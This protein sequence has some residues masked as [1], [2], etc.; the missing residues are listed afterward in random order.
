MD[1]NKI[2]FSYSR[3]D[4]SDFTLRL[5]LDLKKEGFNV[6]I[7]QQDIRAGTEWDLEIEKALETCDCLLFIESEKSVSSN[8]VL[9]EV[10]YALEQRKRV[11]PVIYHDSKTPFRLQRL[12]HIDFTKDYQTGLGNLIEELKRVPAQEI[13]TPA[14]NPEIKQAT[15][16]FLTKY[17]RHLLAIAFLLVIAI[18]AAFIYSSNKEKDIVQIESKELTTNDTL[19]NKQP[20]QD[21]PELPVVPKKENIKSEKKAS[22]NAANKIT[23]RAENKVV[24]PNTDK[25]EN[26]VEAYAGE[27]ELAGVEPKAKSQRGFLRISSIDERKVKILSSFQF[28]FFKP[29]TE[30]HF[31]VFNGFAACESCVLQNEIKIID[32]DVAFGSNRYEILKKD[33]PDKGK[34]GDTVMNRG[35]NNSIS[36]LVTLHLINSNS[37]TIKVQQS[38][39]TPV[40]NDLVVEPFEYSFMFVKK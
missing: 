1:L 13:F 27:W 22:G 39:P 37:I 14:G 11:I 20:R 17:S 2:F 28:Y 33:D 30:A 26:L 32:K 21:A 3:T 10:Y 29:N 8:N 38:K 15:K 25:V 12:Q 36:A 6:W 19:A 40:G 5:A 18:V 24:A 34:A 4:A 31:V 7:D 16:T 35:A 9:D 23:K